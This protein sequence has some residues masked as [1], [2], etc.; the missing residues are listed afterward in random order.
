L[1][2]KQPYQQLSLLQHQ[3]EKLRVTQ[4]RAMKSSFLSS[5]VDG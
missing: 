4:S 3:G 5:Q 1:L 2:D